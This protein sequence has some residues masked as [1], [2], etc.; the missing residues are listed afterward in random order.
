METHPGVGL[1]AALARGTAKS[2]VV[3]KTP[4]VKSHAVSERQGRQSRDVAVYKHQDA[5]RHEVLTHVIVELFPSTNYISFCAEGVPV[6]AIE[7]NL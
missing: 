2:L 6:N 3:T 7:R 1:D 4:S 5:P